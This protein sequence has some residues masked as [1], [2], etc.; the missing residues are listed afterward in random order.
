[1]VQQVQQWL[2]TTGKFKNPVIV[3]QYVRLAILA[4]LQYMPEAQRVR[5]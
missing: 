3:V 5:P 2:F 4:G 1:M